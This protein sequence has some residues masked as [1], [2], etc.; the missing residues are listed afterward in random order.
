MNHTAHTQS[1]R[2][3]RLTQLVRRIGQIALAASLISLG[4]AAFAVP[5]A[6]FQTAFK[7]FIQASAGDTTAIDR[8]AEAFSGL[9]NSEPANPVLCWPTRVPP[10]L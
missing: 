3:T 10:R 5:D 8:A 7:Q 1:H 4:A 2:L 9:L 6:Q